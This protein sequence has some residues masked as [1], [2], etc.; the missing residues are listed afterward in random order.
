MPA[1]HKSF[2]NYKLNWSGG[3]CTECGQTAYMVL[4][5]GKMGASQ[6]KPLCDRHFLIACRENSSAGA[7]DGV[8]SEPAGLAFAH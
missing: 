3:R 2:S 5:T 1:L 8:S 4:E 7:C 6:Y